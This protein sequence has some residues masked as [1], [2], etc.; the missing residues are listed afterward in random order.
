MSALGWQLST[1]P[2]PPGAD[3]A[4]K[5][6]LTQ[7]HFPFPWQP[8]RSDWS[9][10]FTLMG[11]LSFRAS[12]RVG[13]SPAETSLQP[14]CSLCPVLLSPPCF[15]RGCSEEPLSVIFL[16][17]DVYVRV[18]FLGNPT[19]IMGMLMYILF[20]GA[21]NRAI[22]IDVQV[23]VICCVS[24]VLQ[25]EWEPLLWEPWVRRDRKR[26]PSYPSFSSKEA[27]RG[28]ALNRSKDAGSLSPGMVKMW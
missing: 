3:S 9:E 23:T 28:P 16:H 10:G 25:L 11:H 27:S 7:G 24:G 14:S 4:R 17:V 15:F 5:G 19:E 22:E 13:C 6:C 8:V 20:W 2:A 26:F 18:C 21:H 1:G 12:L